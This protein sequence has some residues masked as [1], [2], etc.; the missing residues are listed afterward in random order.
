M[1]NYLTLMPNYICSNGI[2][3]P[4]ILPVNQQKE[5]RPFPNIYVLNALSQALNTSLRNYENQYKIG[6]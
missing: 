6:L 5:I 3:T 4:Y 1:M 2:Q